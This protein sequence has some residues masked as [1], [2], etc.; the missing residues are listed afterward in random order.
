MAAGFTDANFFNARVLSRAFRRVEDEQRLRRNTD[1]YGLALIKGGIGVDK[2]L[3]LTQP[4]AWRQWPP[5]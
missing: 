5:G 3:I 2:Y 4:T 1:F